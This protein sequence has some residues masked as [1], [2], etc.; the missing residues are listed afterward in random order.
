MAESTKIQW[1]DNLRVIATISVIFLHVSASILYRYGRVPSFVWWVGNVFDGSVRYCVPVFVMLSGALLLPRKINVMEFYKKRLIR[2]VLPFLFFACV[3]FIFAWCYKLTPKEKIYDTMH[4][5]EWIISVLKKGISFHFW[6]IYMLLGLYI[7]MP[8]LGKWVRQFTE[9]QFYYFFGFWLLLLFIN[10]PIL[11]FLG[12]INFFTVQIFNRFAYIGYLVLGY[13]LSE[14]SFAKSQSNQYGIICFLMGILI[15]IFGTYFLTTYR[16]HYDG[17]FYSFLSP[18]VLL[19]SIG[20]LLLLKDSTLRN[21][22]LILICD[23][24]S[25]YSFGIYLVHILVL[26][27]FYL[28]GIYWTRWHPLLSVPFITLFCLLVSSIIIFILNKIPFGR[29]ISG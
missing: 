12:N 1:M 10:I 6:F 16:G 20:V 26:D 24:I 15:T 8:F 28:N 2:V 22:A 14:K 13:Y 19:A 17:F 7:L 25:K 21:K 27:I 3:Y 5:S 23:F 9:R 4:F 11:Y 29:Y 18:N